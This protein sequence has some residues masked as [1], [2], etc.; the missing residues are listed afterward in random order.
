MPRDF[1]PRDLDNWITGHYGNDD[2]RVNPGEPGEGQVKCRE[3]GEVFAFEPEPVCY[4]CGWIYRRRDAI[5]TFMS[6]VLGLREPVEIENVHRILSGRYHDPAF[7]PKGTDEL[8]TVGDGRWP[9][10][11]RYD[12]YALY[13]WL[14]EESGEVELY[15]AD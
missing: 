3:C 1:D 12:G 9:D 6:D 5:T 10:R 2:P 4:N 14:S 7:N 11:F 8:W 13:G 15:A